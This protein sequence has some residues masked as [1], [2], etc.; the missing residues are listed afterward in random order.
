MVPLPSDSLRLVTG[1]LFH[2]WNKWKK[3]LHEH[4]SLPDVVVPSQLAYGPVSAT[5]TQA[6][7]LLKFPDDAMFPHTSGQSAR[8]ILLLVVYPE[9]PY[10]LI[11]PLRLDTNSVHLK[12][13]L[14]LL[15][16]LLTQCI[17]TVCV[18]GH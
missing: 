16:R 15:S 18:Q 5:V 14:P 7:L 8:N 1:Y 2:L 9:N 12:P 13:F 4:T 11:N 17:K 3:S 10:T 6:L